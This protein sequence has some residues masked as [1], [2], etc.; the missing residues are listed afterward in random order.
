MYRLSLVQGMNQMAILA[1]YNGQTLPNS[2]LFAKVSL[3]FCRIRN[4]PSKI[5]KQ[6]NSGQ[7]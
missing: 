2:I 6:E 1:I 4:N 7:I 3:K 5:D